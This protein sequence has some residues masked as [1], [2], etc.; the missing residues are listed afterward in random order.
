MRSAVDTAIPVDNLEFLGAE[1]STS[2]V[3]F[4]FESHIS[5]GSPAKIWFLYVVFDLR[6]YSK[7]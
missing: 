2:A 1:T 5:T 7:I 4:Q 6:E 3:K